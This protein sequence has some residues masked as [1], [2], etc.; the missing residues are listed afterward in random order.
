MQ[1]AQLTDLHLRH[2]TPG[3][4]ATNRRRSRLMTDHLAK[5]LATIQTQDVDLLVLTGDLLDAPTWLWES[6]YGFEIDDPSPWLAAIKK[7]YQLIKTMLDDSGLRYVVLPGNHDHPDIFWQVFNRDDNVLEIAGCRVVRFCD[8]EADC[9]QPR[10]FNSERDRFNAMLTDQSS[11]PQIHLQHYVVHP[12]LNKHYPHTYLEGEELTRRSSA[13]GRVKL[14]LSGHYHSGTEL[15]ALDKTTFA[16]GPAFCESPFAWRTY[17]ITA[18]DIQ[19]QQ[20]ALA[21]EPTLPTAAVFLDRDGVINDMASYRV[22]PEEMRLIPGSAKAIASFNKAGLPVIGV[23][24][25]SC[26]GTGYVPAAVVVSVNDKM[27]RLLAQE[28]ASLDAIY[29][30]SGAGSAAVLP[31]Y[32]DVSDCKPQPKHLLDASKLLNLDLSQSWMVGDRIT[33]IQTARNAGAN[34]ILV[35]TGDGRETLAK[36]TDQLQGVPVM[37]DLSAAADFILSQRNPAV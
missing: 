23:T 4:A 11:P 16:T 12:A 28:N 8:R 36:N 13:S 5:A 3:T 29:Y 15:L 21:H 24:S 20:H 7:D 32:E 6:S 1:I 17:D 25:Q 30:S 14:S 35:L 22:G 26:I 2:H 9:H 18:H 33:D 19:F 37:D 27:H 34:P 10:R 31:M